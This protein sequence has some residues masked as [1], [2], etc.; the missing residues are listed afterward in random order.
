MRIQ[1]V[2][3]GRKGGVRT[4]VVVVVVIGV[5]VISVALNRKSITEISVLG[6][7]DNYILLYLLS[8]VETWTFFFQ[9]PSFG[10]F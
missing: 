10:D 8:S 1:I 6:R 9:R 5:V 3:Q 7:I 2:S 4:F